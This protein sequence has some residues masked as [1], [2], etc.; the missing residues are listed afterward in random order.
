MKKDF[1]KVLIKNPGEEPKHALMI[2]SLEAFQKA[3]GG[4]IE[5]YP[6]PNTNAVII[7]DE[8]GKLKGKD[9]NFWV[10]GN[11]EMLVGTVVIVGVEEDYFI[12]TPIGLRDFVG[13]IRDD[14]GAYYCDS[15]ECWFD[16]PATEKVDLEDMYGVG[17]MFS[18]HHFSTFLCCPFCGSEDISE[19]GDLFR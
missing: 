7:C 19:K 9:F 16:E 3:V 12:D 15:C 11:F 1:V 8:E 17:S 14:I 18:D 6:L 5:C 13:Q 4:Y 2:N 10:P